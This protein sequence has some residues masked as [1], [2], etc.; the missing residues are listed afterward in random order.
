MKI[1]MHDEEP[2]RIL[3]PAKQFRFAGISL[4]KFSERQ[5]IVVQK[6]KRD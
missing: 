3:T 6:A 2:A 5:K 1:I 4:S